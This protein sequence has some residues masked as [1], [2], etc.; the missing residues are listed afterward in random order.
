MS[1]TTIILLILGILGLGWAI[2]CFF[3]VCRPFLSD[4]S[5]NNNSRRD[6]QSQSA[7]LTDVKV[8]QESEELPLQDTPSTA[9]PSP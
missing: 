3:N 6:S 2:W 7:Q 8:Q 1:A 9:T 5:S 4:K